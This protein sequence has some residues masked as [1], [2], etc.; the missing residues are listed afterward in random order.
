VRHHAAYA[1][2]AIGGEGHAALCQLA[3]HA[4]DRYAREMARDAL[5]FGDRERQA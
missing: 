1:L 4:D 5:D 3:A 2:A